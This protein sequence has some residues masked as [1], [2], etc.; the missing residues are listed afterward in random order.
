MTFAHEP[1]S[2]W[3]AE[4]AARYLNVSRSLIYKLEQAG[5]LPCMKIGSCIRF[6]P[7]EVRAFARGEHS[8]GGIA[9]DRGAVPRR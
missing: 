1:E 5:E 9:R 7:G 4:A 8:M 2:L 3:D 6:E